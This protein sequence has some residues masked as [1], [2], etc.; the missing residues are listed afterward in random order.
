MAVL[1]EIFDQ[2]Q[3]P[4]EFKIALYFSAL[5]GYEIEVVERAA[6]EIIKSRVYPAFPK[7]GEIILEIEGTG[8]DRAV[9]A[10]GEVVEAIKKTGPYPSVAFN[11]PTIH[12]VIEFMGGWPAT[13]D[14]LQ[15]ELKWK[16]K[17]FER[18]YSIMKG[19]GKEVKYLLGI[20]ETQNGLNG[21]EP[22]PVLIGGTKEVALRVGE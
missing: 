15:D 10:W 14:W 20:I 21:K 12:A 1:A 5:S 8:E 6:A 17:E 19:R 7:P 3:E 2:G 18:L 4:S 22:S 13:G 9:A 11:D 16:Q